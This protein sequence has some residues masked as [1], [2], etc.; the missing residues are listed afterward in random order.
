MG[1]KSDQ[2]T[3]EIEESRAA[4]GEDLQ[5]LE[6]K[7]KHLTDWR[8]HF[9]QNPLPLLAA[10]FAGGLLLALMVNGRDR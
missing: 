3:K 6:D 9:R 8:E 2:I 5:Q 4:L 10:A 7:V 1:E